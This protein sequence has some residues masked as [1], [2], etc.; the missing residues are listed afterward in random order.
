MVF[1]ST[2]MLS[3]ILA[4]STHLYMFYDPQ[5]NVLALSQVGKG[6]CGRE[7]YE[8]YDVYNLD[9]GKCYKLSSVL[10]NAKMVA[11]DETGDRKPERIYTYSSD[12]GW[13]QRK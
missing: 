4:A 9:D 2:P 12:R 3:I 8:A 13:V 7:G 1:L 10:F 6:M 5:H 11:I